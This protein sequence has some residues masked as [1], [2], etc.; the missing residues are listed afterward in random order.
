MSQYSVEQ[1]KN[2]QSARSWKHKGNGKI[3]KVTPWLEI[4]DPVVQLTASEAMKSGIT[5]DERIVKFGT[6][7]QVGWL[8]ETEN[9]IYCGFSLDVSDCFEDVTDQEMK[10]DGGKS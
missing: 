5:K 9:N 7:V 2:L 4:P 10:K 3:V 6:L 8:I 1:V